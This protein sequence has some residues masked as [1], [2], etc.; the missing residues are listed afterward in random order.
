VEYGP[1]PL[2]PPDVINVMNSP[3]AFCFSLLFGIIVKANWRAKRWR[4]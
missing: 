4:M 2:H 1:R 3:K